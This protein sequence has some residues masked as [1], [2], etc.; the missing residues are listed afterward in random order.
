MTGGVK[1]EISY[2]KWTSSD[3]ARRAVNCVYGL[4]AGDQMTHRVV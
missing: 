3:I 1:H 4:L 2:D